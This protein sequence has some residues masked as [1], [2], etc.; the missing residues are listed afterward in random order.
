[1][2]PVLASL[3]FLVLPYCIHGCTN[4]RGEELCS[5]KQTVLRRFDSADVVFWASLHS[6]VTYDELGQINMLAT[7]EHRVKGCLDLQTKTV[8]IISPCGPN[9]VSR[10]NE[11]Q[12]YLISGQKVAKPPKGAGFDLQVVSTNCDFFLLKELVSNWDLFQLSKQTEACEDK[13]T[14]VELDRCS[15]NSLP[16]DC[17]SQQVCGSLSA[18][19]RKCPVAQSCAVN[20]CNGCTPIFFGKNGQRVCES[21]RNCAGNVAATTCRTDVCASIRN[22]Q[23]FDGCDAAETCLAAHVYQTKDS[24]IPVLASCSQCQPVFADAYGKQVC[25]DASPSL[26][27]QDLRGVSF[28]ADKCLIPTKL[29]FGVTGGV[30]QPV[31]GCAGAP[32]SFVLFPDLRSC[33]SL[34]ACLDLSA[35][36]TQTGGGGGEKEGYCSDVLGYYFNR[37]AG[38]CVELTGCKPGGN[39]TARATAA[40][41]RYASRG[42]FSDLA[43]CATSCGGDTAAAAAYVKTNPSSTFAVRTRPPTSR[44]TPLDLNVPP[45]A[46]P[47]AFNVVDIQIFDFEPFSPSQCPADQPPINGTCSTQACKV[48][49]PTC[50]QAYGK[51]LV[52]RVSNCGGCKAV[53]TVRQTGGKFDCVRHPLPCNEAQ[54]AEAEAGAAAG[55]AAQAGSSGAQPGGGGGNGGGGG[56]K[57]CI[58]MREGTPPQAPWDCSL[59]ALQCDVS[60]CVGAVRCEHDNC[61]ACS[62]RFFDKLGKEIPF[63]QCRSAWGALPL[64][65]HKHSYV[66]STC[67]PWQP[68]CCPDGHA[69]FE[70]D[71]A[72]AAEVC[73]KL[74]LECD[75]P[76]SACQAEACNFCAVRLLDVNG[77]E[78]DPAKR[79]RK[80]PPPVLGCT[81]LE[82]CSSNA[83][84]CS[85]EVWAMKSLA[86]KG[87][88]T[89]LCKPPFTGETCSLPFNVASLEIAG[90]TGWTYSEKICKRRE[91]LG[92]RF[93]DD[94]EGCLRRCVEQFGDR[95]EAVFMAWGR[96]CSVCLPSPLRRTNTK[97]GFMLTRKETASVSLAPI[98]AAPV[99]AG[100]RIDPRC[101]K[102]ICPDIP[103][104][105]C[106]VKPKAC[107]ASVVCAQEPCTCTPVWLNTNTFQVAKCAASL[108][109]GC[110]LPHLCPKV[111]DCP[112]PTPKDIERLG[113][114]ITC[115]QE[116]CTCKPVWV[117]LPCPRCSSI[118]DCPAPPVSMVETLPK[119]V[120]DKIGCTQDLCTCAPLYILPPG[121][122]LNDPVPPTSLPTPKPTALPT[123]TVPLPEYLKP[124]PT[125]SPTILP[126]ASPTAS[127]TAPQPPLPLHSPISIFVVTPDTPLSLLPGTQAIDVMKLP[128]CKTLCPAVF[129]CPANGRCLQELCT[130]KPVY[131][132]LS[133]PAARQPCA[134]TPF[135]CLAPD[136]I[137]YK[138]LPW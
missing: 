74:D 8:Q 33:Q 7:I 105:N 63:K 76:L 57:C 132:P 84:F 35:V 106:G 115:R 78:I 30:C 97:A 96:V 22:G 5:S 73:R 28:D 26:R 118:F 44:P 71:L 34:C 54:G 117:S 24:A 104:L 64:V 108:T 51:D 67:D 43:S 36:D 95:C 19:R 81:S 10:N 56:G 42:L 46:K 61:N 126:T 116:P 14:K 65:P 99:K 130:C 111:F 32:G 86:P 31:T 18:I 20:R 87:H 80:K 135:N 12:L 3:L 122:Q 70:C 121:I 29:G 128:T 52:C 17:S 6:T 100:P 37:A 82:S 1:M 123:A 131:L 68:N 27:C 48:S 38:G 129:R 107:G 125:S 55:A 93:N 11:T 88:P 94:I 66:R 91:K 69:P 58:S 112:R 119:L 39:G 90:L 4:G 45:K 138:F 83:R 133:C 15:D 40:D 49:I 109:K 59:S 25:K 60:M 79:C 92:A 21:R 103:L 136:P 41:T 85:R 23:K 113:P 9:A 127:P 13:D 89:C 72:V 110:V 137:L 134:P 124:K 47:V 114:S 75:V 62:T 98:L 77:V 53:W 120:L 16:W 2:L 101:P 50:P 102:V